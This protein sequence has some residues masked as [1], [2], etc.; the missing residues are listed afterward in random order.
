MSRALWI[1]QKNQLCHLIKQVSDGYGGD[2]LGWLREY[3]KDTVEGFKDDL[4]KAIS[5][6]EYLTSGIDKKFL[7]T[8]NRGFKS[9]ACK[10]CGY[11]VPFCRFDLGGHC[12]NVSRRTLK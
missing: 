11:V 1:A 2:E 5:C 8:Q 7:K 4:G 6:F 9:Y 12:T 10:L 3:A